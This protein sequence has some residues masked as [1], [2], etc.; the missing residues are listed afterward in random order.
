LKKG[1]VLVSIAGESIDQ[2]SPGLGVTGIFFIVK[3]DRQQLMEIARLIDGGF[4]RTIIAGV[5]PLTEAEQAFEMLTECGKV[6][7]IVLRVD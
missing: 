5:F 1:G 3:P 7:K 2:P 4:V 6:G